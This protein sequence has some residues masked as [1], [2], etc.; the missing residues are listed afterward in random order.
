[1]S[2]KFLRILISLIFHVYRLVEWT[3]NTLWKNVPRMNK[4]HHWTAIANAKWLMSHE[5]IRICKWHFLHLHLKKASK[6]A[7]L[8]V[9]SYQF[10]V[11]DDGIFMIMIIVTA[12]HKLTSTHTHTH[13][14]DL[15]SFQKI[16]QPT[17]SPNYG[18]FF[19]R[20]NWHQLWSWSN[21]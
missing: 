1:M 5:L 3:M 7:T 21:E 4:E 11:W 12:M 20:W 9:T 15:L 18:F 13:R 17:I 8:R 16:T 14:I 2:I 19:R 10:W 6:W